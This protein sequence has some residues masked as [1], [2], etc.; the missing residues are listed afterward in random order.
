MFGL[1]EQRQW[2]IK[3][4]CKLHAYLVHKQFPG[5]LSGIHMADSSRLDSWIACVSLPGC[6]GSVEVVDTS[7]RH[8]ER[9]LVVL[10]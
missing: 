5:M 4:P 9:D 2:I 7:V 10:A 3:G 1:V 8:V 6:T